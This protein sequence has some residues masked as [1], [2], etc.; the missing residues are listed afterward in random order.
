MN[1]PTNA[2]GPSGKSTDEPRFAID[3]AQP[4]SSSNERDA[5]AERE[6]GTI[7]AGTLPQDLH[8]GTTPEA[9]PLIK[10]TADEQQPIDAVAEYQALSERED[11]TNVG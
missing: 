2:A 10:L 9:F 8:G 4:E 1:S 7:R 11:G 5:L 3:E 6:D